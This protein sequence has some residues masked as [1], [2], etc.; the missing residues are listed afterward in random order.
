MSN[1]FTGLSLQPPLGDPRLDL[2]DLYAFP[3][4]DDASRTALVLTANPKADFLYP[5]AVYR[6]GIDNDGDLR[7]DIAF[8]FVFGE[9]ADGGQTVDVYLAVDDEAG[10]EQAV[11]SR[12][13]DAVAVSTGETAE[14]YESGSFRFYAGARSDPL[15]VDYDGIGTL[16]ATKDGLEGA[17]PPAE[18]ESPWTGVDSNAEANVFAIVLDLPTTALGA[19][20][21]IRI[22]SR[23]SVYRDGELLHVDRVGHPAV[24]DFFTVDGTKEEY[25]ASEP[26]RDRDRWIGT[27]IEL[28]T[29]TGGYNRQGAVEAIDREGTLPDMLTYDPAKPAGYPNGRTLAD[30]VVDYR[31]AFL[32]TGRTPASGL[33]PHTDTTSDFPYLGAPHGS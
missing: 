1:H 25:D 33:S 15:F 24:S 19:T 14:V 30:D 21:D 11:G 20:P 13:F 5:G 7:N 26:V 10:A 12:I 8:S 27:L 29:R 32:T 23:C 22:W 28:L 31:L 4:P 18:A 16:L 9:P 6:I 2:C 3:S 17:A